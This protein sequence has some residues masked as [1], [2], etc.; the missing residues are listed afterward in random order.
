[1]TD[2]GYRGRGLA[3][4]LMEA[5]LADGENPFAGRRAMFPLLSHA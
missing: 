3:R 5:V 1:M 4:R 2:P